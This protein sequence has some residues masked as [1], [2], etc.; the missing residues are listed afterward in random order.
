M[1]WGIVEILVYLLLL[2]LIAKPPFHSVFRQGNWVA[3]RQFMACETAN[4]VAQCLAGCLA[5]HEA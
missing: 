1:V 4:E 3:R 2:G 5:E